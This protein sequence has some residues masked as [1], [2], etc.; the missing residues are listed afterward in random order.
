MDGRIVSVA[1][2]ETIRPPMTRAA[3]RRGLRAATLAHPDSH[4]QH[5]ED[6]R[7]GSHQNGSQPAGRAFPRRF[8]QRPA[9]VTDERSAK[10]TSRIEL[11][12]AIPIAMIAP[13]KD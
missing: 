8:E 1:N 3:E 4:G 2:V 9:F 10:E 5:A 7:G 6:H 12:T 13:M 11:A